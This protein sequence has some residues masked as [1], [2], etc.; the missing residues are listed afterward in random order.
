MRHTPVAVPVQDGN[1]DDR[2]PRLL[3][4]HERQPARAD[5]CGLYEGATGVSVRTAQ[6]VGIAA[7]LTYR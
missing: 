2:A 3:R 1:S 6:L 5:N 4:A 7:W